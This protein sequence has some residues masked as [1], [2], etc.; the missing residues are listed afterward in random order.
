MAFRC[1]LCKCCEKGEET[2]GGNRSKEY[3]LPV[4]DSSSEDEEY[5][6]EEVRIALVG[7][8]GSGKSS[9][10]NTILGGNYF[11]SGVC[12]ASITSSSHRC[13]A[14]RFKREIHVVDT[15]G[16]FDTNTPNEEVLAEIGKCIGLTCPG[17]HCILLVLGLTRFTK[18]EKDSIDLFIKQFGNNVFRYF[19]IVFTRKDDLDRDG[20]TIDDFVESAPENL[21]VIIRKFSNR[22]IAFNNRADSPEKETQVK[23]LLKMIDEVVRQNNGTCYTNFM[24]ENTQKILLRRKEQIEN[25]RKRDKERER[26]EM[27]R[28]IEQRFKDRNKQDLEKQKGLKQIND[29]YDQ[30][31]NSMDE[32]KNEVENKNLLSRYVPEIFRGVVPVFVSCLKSIVF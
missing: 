28:T 17:P 6:N 4:E 31:P 10:G 7:K 32:V 22:Y 21:K 20:K 18:E 5:F 25:Q 2:H 16:V 19:I 3:E 11:S 27:E 15:P 1:C 8:T 9:T 30:L 13:T 23:H 12:G 24:Y 26:K 29:K 14:R